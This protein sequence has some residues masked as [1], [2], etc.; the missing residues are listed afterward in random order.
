MA[1]AQAEGVC[2]IN[3]LLDEMFAKILDLVPITDVFVDMRVSKRWE[4][5]CRQAVQSRKSLIIG[6]Y[7]RFLL[8]TDGIKMRGWNW[9]KDQPSQ[10]LDKVRVANES[11]VPMM[12]S[13]ERMKNVS[14]LCV[15]EIRSQRVR[16]FIGKLSAQLTLLGVDFAVSEV[17]AGVFPRLTHLYCR[18]F[19]GETASAFPKLAELLIMDPERVRNMR[20]PSLKRLLL[21]ASCHDHQ[22]MKRFILSHSENLEFLHVSDFQLKWD[23]AVVFKS[24]IDLDIG[25]IDVD[26]VRSLPAIRR[27]SLQEDA[28]VA[29][30]R[31]LPAAQMLSLNVS[32]DFDPA[33]SD[34][35]DDGEENEK[36]G[37]EEFSA[38]ISRMSNLKELSILDIGEEASNGQDPYHAFSS[39]INRLRQLERA[40]IITDHTRFVHS[41][42]NGDSVVFSLVQQNPNLRDLRL[43]GIRFTPAAFASLA[44]LQHLSHVS[45]NLCYQSVNS[46]IR[47]ELTSNVITL[48]R[49]SSRNV[50]LKLRIWKKGLKIPQVM[51]E[52]ERMAQE[53]GTKVEKHDD[54]SICEFKILA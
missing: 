23:R 31:R 8:C 18:N 9:H 2:Y 33:A 17:G 10:Q 11:L 34:D 46:D 14:R 25:S 49:G 28:K 7:I 40:Y 15:S 27:L 53:R 50:I 52:V 54:G 16:K 32:F 29:V 21:Y 47:R 12:K 38:V 26:M 42:S 43:R 6:D 19:D 4:D 20:L 45:L 13:V 5:V 35:E 3:E 37:P 36:D 1:L 22:P 44:Q 39:M 51:R 48:L 24:M 41:G 30:L